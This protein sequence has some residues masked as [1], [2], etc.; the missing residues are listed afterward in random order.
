M[1]WLAFLVESLVMAFVSQ[2][3]LAVVD[4]AQAVLC[5]AFLGALFVM[6]LLSIAPL[7]AIKGAEAE[8]G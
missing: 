1:L 4:G 2:S 7:A 8:L 3:L 5:K 6:P